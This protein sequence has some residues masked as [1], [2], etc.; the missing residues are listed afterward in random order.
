MDSSGESHR[1]NE[2]PCLRFSLA[3]VRDSPRA[4]LLERAPHPKF[5]A[6]SFDLSPR[7]RGEVTSNA[8]LGCLKIKS[9]ETH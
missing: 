5:A 1:G 7:G 6:A 2:E 9:E 4:V 8:S 3:P